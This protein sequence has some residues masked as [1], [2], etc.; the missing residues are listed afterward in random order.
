MASSQATPEVKGKSKATRYLLI[1]GLVVLAS[2][3][4]RLDAGGWE[5]GQG[6][7]G[8][9]GRCGRVRLR[10]SA[11]DDGRHAPGYD[12]RSQPR[13]YSA[14]INQFARVRTY[15]NP[16]FKN[17]V[18]ISVNSLWSVAFPDLDKEPMTVSSPDI[19][20][21]AGNGHVDGQLHVGGLTHQRRQGWHL[22]HCR[23]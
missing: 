1:L 7:C 3:D 16:D 19:H 9:H 5:Q 18:R 17:V 10:I 11:G 22:S 4:C 14:P 23:S 13:E 2:P 21:G 8:T 6:S 20:R 15:V 12:R